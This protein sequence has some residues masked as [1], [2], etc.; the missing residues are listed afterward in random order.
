[1][2]IFDTRKIVPMIDI[3]SSTMV[4][5]EIGGNTLTSSITNNIL[6]INAINNTSSSIVVTVIDDICTI[7]KTE[8]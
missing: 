7:Y 8:V 3:V 1:M 6:T 5:T 4:F 2:Y